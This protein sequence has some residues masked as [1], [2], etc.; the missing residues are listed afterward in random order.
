MLLDPKE[1]V[2]K[3]GTPSK[4]AD[5]WSKV[6][7]PVRDYEE[8]VYYHDLNLTAAVYALQGL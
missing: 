4:D 3:E 6:S 1:T 8:R 7:A 5:Q 2:V